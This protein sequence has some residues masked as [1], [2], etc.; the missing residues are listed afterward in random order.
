MA[1]SRL[2]I[3]IHSVTQHEP[4]KSEGNEKI[5]IEVL[6]LSDGDNELSRDSLAS[7]DSEAER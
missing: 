7:D 2:D 3:S 4:N 6:G 5:D 1:Q